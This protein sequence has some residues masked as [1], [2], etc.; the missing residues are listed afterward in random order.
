MEEQNSQYQQIENYE[1]LRSEVEAA[2]K[3]K[4]CTPKDFEYLRERIYARLH[5]LVSRT[6]LMR[7]WGY[8]DEDVTPRK[9]TLDILSRLLGY[10][11]WESFQK[12]AMLSK[13]QQSNPVMSR[14]LSVNSDLCIGERLRLT[15]QPGRVCDLEYLGELS[16]R[17]IASENTRI[18]SGDTFQC[19]LIVEG[20]PLY[21]DNLRKRDSSSSAKPI[22]YVCGKKT[23]VYFEF[24][25]P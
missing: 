5:T 13:E 20:E 6:T 23:G 18:Q 12:N 2:L 10:Q 24:C 4:L 14:K 16:F 21:L 11:D 22:A 8:V 15:W 17:V 19:S 7:L 9:G 25:K 1:L 3:K